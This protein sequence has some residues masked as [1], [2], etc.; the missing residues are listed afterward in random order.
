M[1]NRLVDVFASFERHRVRYVII[2]GVAAILHGVP[3]STF[4]VDVLI[5]ASLENA[6]ALLLAFEDAG[7][8]TASLTSP[9]E[10][11]DNA[12]TIFQDRVRID[13]QTRTPGLTFEGAWARR[14]TLEYSGQTFYVLCREDVIASKLASGRPVDLDDV[15][16]LRDQDKDGAS[17]D[18]S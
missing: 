16:A 15:R 12:I 3:R 9:E 14:E 1:L 6:Q 11:V 8:G 13:V 2:G 18:Q 10:V 7:L 5:D 4:D 17:S